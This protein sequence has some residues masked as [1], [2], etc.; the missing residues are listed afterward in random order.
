MDVNIPIAITK[1]QITR[2]IAAETGLSQ[3]EAEKSLSVLYNIIKTTLSTGESISIRGFG[4]FYVKHQR[5][6]KIRHP[7]T[8]KSI[9]IGPKKVARFKY[10]KSLLQEINFADFDIDKFNRENELILKQLYDLIKNSGD[11]EEEEEEEEIQNSYKNIKAG[12]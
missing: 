11:Y 2:S 5:K 12:P 7:S 3:I 1:S 9:I 10:F 6:R 8:G 4:K